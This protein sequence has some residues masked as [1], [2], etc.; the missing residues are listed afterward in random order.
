MPPQLQGKTAIEG[1]LEQ[2][3]NEFGEWTYDIPLGDGIWT[4]G[5]LNIPHTRL[6]RLV[7]IV[8]DICS[9]PI[10]ECRVLDLGC[11]DGLFSIEFA[12]QGAETVGVEIREANVKK[13][14]FCREVLGL[15][16]LKFVQ[17]D[18]RNISQSTHGVF[19]VIICSGI[20]YHLPARDAIKLVETMHGMVKEILI[21]DTRITTEAVQSLE[22]R[23]VEYWGELMFEH[24]AKATQDQKAKKLLSSWDNEQS[25]HFTRPSL[26]NLLSASGFSSVYECFI[27]PHINYGRPGIECQTRCTFVAVKNRP[28][29]LIASPAANELNE[30]WPEDSLTFSV[31]AGSSRGLFRKLFGKNRR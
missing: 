18:V 4:R 2:L 1:R 15:N 26:V 16:N 17:A 6:K 5:N 3:K 7:Q 22:H 20:L 25:F 31:E 19:D 12:S 30:R 9:K 29:K 28:Q 23:G 24:S 21:V 11:L 27:P 8:N 13:A 10:S 14:E